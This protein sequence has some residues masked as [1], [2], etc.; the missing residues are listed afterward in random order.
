M[1][2]FL[3]SSRD[4]QGFPGDLVRDSEQPASVAFRTQRLTVTR[5]ATDLFEEPSRRCRAVSENGGGGRDESER[6]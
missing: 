4:R 3:H 1:I 6:A 2:L 5:E